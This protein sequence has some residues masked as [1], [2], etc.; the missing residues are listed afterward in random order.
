MTQTIL[1]TTTT[2]CVTWTW[3]DHVTHIDMASS[4]QVTTE[5]LPL[6]FTQNFE[7]WTR[8]SW[9]H[10]KPITAR[11]FSYGYSNLTSCDTLHHHGAFW[12]SSTQSAD[13][14]NCSERLQIYAVLAARKKAFSVML[15]ILPLEWMLQKHAV[16]YLLKLNHLNRFPKISPTDTLSFIVWWYGWFNFHSSGWAHLTSIQ[17]QLFSKKKT[18]RDRKFSKACLVTGSSY[19]NELTLSLLKPVLSKTKKGLILGSVSYL[20]AAKIKEAK[21]NNEQT[22]T[23]TKR[24]TKKS[25]VWLWGRRT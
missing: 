15:G 12:E 8:F 2:M 10:W 11:K 21:P 1:T 16:H 23:G 13:V 3:H 5:R 20:E 14:R 19:S 18:I 7:H 9:V 22:K 24:A 4:N 25:V 17:W 6:H